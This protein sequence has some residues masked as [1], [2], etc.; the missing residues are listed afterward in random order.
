M[1]RYGIAS[2]KKLKSYE[3]LFKSIMY[4]NANYL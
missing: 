1:Q 3:V 4:E 2:Y